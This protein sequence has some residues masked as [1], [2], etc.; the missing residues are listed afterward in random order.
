MTHY[1]ARDPFAA[2]DDESEESQSSLRPLSLSQLRPLSA[3]VSLPPLP[4]VPDFLSLQLTLSAP[5]RFSEPSLLSVCSTALLGPLSPAEVCS[6]GHRCV[7]K[8]DDAETQR[9]GFKEVLCVL[10]LLRMPGVPPQVRS[11][12]PEVL[13]CLETCSSFCA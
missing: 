7:C 13:T 12:E 2:G 11:G 1:C 5:G 10:S 8:A 4:F 6:A 3:S 9:R